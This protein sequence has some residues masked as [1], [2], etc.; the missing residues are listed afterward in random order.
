MKNIGGGGGDFSPLPAPWWLQP[1]QQ[2]VLIL[3]IYETFKVALCFG[4]N[5][6]CLFMV[7]NLKSDIEIE[8]IFCCRKLP[9][10][11]TTIAFFTIKSTCDIKMIS[12]CKLLPMW[13]KGL[14]DYPIFTVEF[15]QMQTSRLEGHISNITHSENHNLSTFTTMNISFLHDKSGVSINVDFST[16]VCRLLRGGSPN[17][18]NDSSQT[19]IHSNIFHITA[20]TCPLMNIF[21]IQFAPSVIKPLGLN[22]RKNSLNAS[23]Q[24]E[25]HGKVFL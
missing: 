25:I 11:T 2:Q 18:Q 6:L 12:Y 24:V 16:A 7:K 19:D 17:T 8:R 4:L 1:Q 13:L 10:F 3:K 14:K 9:T 22:Y 5:Q 23:S 20:V 21:Q 15:P